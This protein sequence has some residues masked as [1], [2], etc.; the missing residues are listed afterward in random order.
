MYG[1]EIVEKIP[2]KINFALRKSLVQDR[3]Q[4]RIQEKVQDKFGLGKFS[5]I[6]CFFAKNLKMS[7]MVEKL[8][9]K[10][11]LKKILD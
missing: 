7:C 11:P 6:F 4:D 10:I 8:W 9:K 3:V 1:G 2:L 5:P